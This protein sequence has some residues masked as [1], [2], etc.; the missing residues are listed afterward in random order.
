MTKSYY[1]E[2]V[3]SHAARNSANSDGGV[4]NFLIEH[5]TEEQFKRAIAV[6]TAMAI[7][8]GTRRAEKVGMSASEI[9][10]SL[11]TMLAEETDCRT[12]NPPEN[13]VTGN[14]TTVS[15]NTSMGAVATPWPATD[16][17]VIAIMDALAP[18]IRS[19]LSL[20]CF[21]RRD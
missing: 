18:G 16:E 5:A 15:K 12:T 21:L 3:N 2:A 9:R 7:A 13:S 6:Y 4:L 1:H 19:F 11:N 14:A 20:E 17:E 8:D 10:Q